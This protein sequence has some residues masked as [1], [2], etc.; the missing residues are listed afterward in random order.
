[1][2]GPARPLSMGTEIRRQWSRRRTKL[3]LGLLAVLPPI[4]VLAFYL[5]SDDDGGESFVDRA[6]MGAANFTVFTLI[7]SATFLLVVVVAL[8]FGDTV[9]SEAS[10][11]SLRYLLGIPVPRSRLLAVKLAVSALSS[12][13]ALV[14]LTGSAL[15]VGALAFGWNPIRTPY[16]DDI[17]ADLAAWRIAGMVAYLAVTLIVI[18]SLGF[19][20]SVRTDAPL[21]AVGGAVLLY[22]VSGILDQVESLGA[23]RGVLPTHYTDAWQGLFADPIQLEEMAKGSISAL[24]YGAVFFALAFWRFHRADV[25]S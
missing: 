22:V 18:A 23:I 21:A 10:W 16:G 9:A 3:A 7:V 1:M 19:L 25:L 4:L 6:M 14:V 2:S 17:P 15:L 20:L 12:L 24:L 8:F 11:G 5:G 13:A